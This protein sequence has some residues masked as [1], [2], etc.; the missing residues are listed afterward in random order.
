MHPTA[1]H[2]RI[3]LTRF[4]PAL[5]HFLVHTCQVLQADGGT[6]CAAINAAVLALAVAG[7]PLRDLVAAVAAGHLDATP[8]LDLNALE[9][10]GGGPDLAVALGPKTD[11]LLLVQMDNRLPVDTFQVGRWLCWCGRGTGT[12]EAGAH[13]TGAG[14]QDARSAHVSGRCQEGGFEGHCEF[15]VRCLLLV[16]QAWGAAGE[17]R[18][19]GRW[20]TN[21]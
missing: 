2:P 19:D 18:A 1:P 14:I 16:Q 15:G 10:A 20:G 5:H 21:S 6:R 7:I 11:T 3:P 9:D 13:G 17:V 12:S 4:A 8:L